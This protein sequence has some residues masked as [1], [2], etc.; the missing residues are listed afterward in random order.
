M[1]PILEKYGKVYDAPRA[2]CDKAR[3]DLGLQ[4]HAIEDTLRETGQT[5]LDLGLI[6]AKRNSDHPSATLRNGR[7]WQE[8]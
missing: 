5:M 7:V 1:G 4:T 8:P 2:H 3:T 6:E